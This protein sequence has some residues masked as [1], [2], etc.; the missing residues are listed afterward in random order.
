MFNKFTLWGI[1]AVGVIAVVW[2]ILWFYSSNIF[3]NNIRDFLSENELNVQINYEA[4]TKA[5]FPNRTDVTISGL[6]IES[7]DGEFVWEIGELAIHKLVYDFSNYI[8]VFPTTQ[9]FAYKRVSYTLDTERIRT[10]VSLSRD[11]KI[12]ID[13]FITE[14]GETILSSSDSWQQKIQS[15][16]IALQ[17][18]PD[19]QDT[20][21][22]YQGFETI[23]TNGLPEIASTLPFLFPLIS[24]DADIGVDNDSD[25]SGCTTI[26]TIDLKALKLEAGN[27]S[28]NFP[29]FLE[30]NEE[31]YPE[32]ELKLALSGDFD[33]LENL[34]AN[35]GFNPI[36]SRVIIETASKV[37]LPITFNGRT[38]NITNFFEVDSFQFQSICCLNGFCKFNITP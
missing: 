21:Q 34:L 20:Y 7:L 16:I 11:S 29:G 28:A 22:I 33:Q 3:E 13:A 19:L 1:A 37:N 31:G 18:N 27:Y 23:Q 12:S 9:S 30:L 17:E 10:S 2:C 24:Y 35:Y 26:Q 38:I 6:T 14:F 5:G 36:Q 4:I 8:L 15:G 32:G 25:G